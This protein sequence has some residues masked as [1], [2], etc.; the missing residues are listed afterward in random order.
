MWMTVNTSS[1]FD[2]FIDASRCQEHV[3][4]TVPQPQVLQLETFNMHIVNLHPAQQ[5]HHDINGDGKKDQKEKINV[6]LIRPSS[7]G[8]F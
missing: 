1:F 3:V 7:H 4:R 8:Q 2:M 6:S 5:H